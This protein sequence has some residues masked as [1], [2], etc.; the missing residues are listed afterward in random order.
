MSIYNVNGKPSKEKIEKYNEDRYTFFRFQNK[1][2]EM[3]NKSWGMI[4]SS[5]EE[6]REHYEDDGF[7]SE[8]DAILDGKSACSNAEDL[9]NFCSCFDSNYRVLVINGSCVGEGHDGEDVVDVDEIV[10]VWDSDEFI[11]FMNEN[12]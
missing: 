10:E 9:M 11:G 1:D 8:A 2:W 5:E 7:E 6:A 4:Y 3:G 12:Y